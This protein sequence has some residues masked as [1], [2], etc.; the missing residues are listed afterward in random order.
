MYYIIKEINEQQN[1]ADDAPSDSL[2]PFWG[3]FFRV[4]SDTQS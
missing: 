2:D 4:L 1:E 3:P